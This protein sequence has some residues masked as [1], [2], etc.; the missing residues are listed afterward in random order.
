MK[1]LRHALEADQL[2][3]QFGTNIKNTLHET[4]SFRLQNEFSIHFIE[5]SGMSPET[6]NRRTVK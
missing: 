5:L 2:L 3:A 1:M 6:R 4:D